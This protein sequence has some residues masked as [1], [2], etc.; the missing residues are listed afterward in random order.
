MQAVEKEGYDLILMDCFMPVMDGYEATRLI[1]ER[2]STLS[3]KPVPIVA[4]TA[5]VSKENREKCEAIGMVDFLLKPYEPSQLIEK[6]QHY[7]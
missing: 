2:E 3:L 5:D 4:L 6:I 7:L 1:R